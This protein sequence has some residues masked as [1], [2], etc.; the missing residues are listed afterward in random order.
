MPV[1]PPPCFFMY[2]QDIN[3]WRFF[4][5]YL[6]NVPRLFLWTAPCIH[7]LTIARC[8]RPERSKNFIEIRTN[9][10]YVGPDTCF[11][12]RTPDHFFSNVRTAYPV[13]TLR[14]RRRG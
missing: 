7:F 6:V 4:A 13:G 5:G 10:R 9:Y 1:I 14:G 12:I 2:L 11:Q 3:Y 8:A